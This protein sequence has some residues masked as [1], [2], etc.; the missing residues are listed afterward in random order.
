[1]DRLGAPQR[2]DRD[3]GV[4]VSAVQ[5]SELLIHELGKVRREGTHQNRHLQEHLVEDAEADEGLVVA[6]DPFQ[7]IAIEPHEPVGELADE[8][9]QARHDRVQTVAVHLLVDILDEPLQL[10]QD[11]GV[12][13]VLAGCGF[14]PIR[15]K[16][17]CADVLPSE[18]LLRQE[19]QRVV[20]RQDDIPDD[21]HHAIF[22]ESEGIRANRGGIDEIESQRIRAVLADD[23]RGVRIILQPLRH[24]LAVRREHQAVDDH[25]LE[26]GLVKQRR[27]QH[28]QCVEPATRLVET[29]GDELRRE[30]L[31]E[32][33]LVL[34]RIV[35]LGVRHR[36]GFEPAIKDLRHAAKGSF[37]F[38]RG[39]RDV[40]D[41]L[42]VQVLDLLA[43]ELLQLRDG[44]H[45]HH[46]LHI[47]GDP[48]RNRRSP[49]AVP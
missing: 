25:I 31:L 42:H 9:H 26:R 37:P 48:Q 35:D 49:E 45:G 7:A 20:P 8:V 21:A 24:L 10:G 41:V 46:L 44:G 6:V 16:R 14:F 30:S 33:P 38:P 43:R 22:F 15:H 34:K 47:I 5:R 4:V 29:L 12:D 13:H 36:P 39:N 3:G 28:H 19:A 1:M 40:L 18:D 23:Q 2:I 11:P 32:G 17:L 27:A